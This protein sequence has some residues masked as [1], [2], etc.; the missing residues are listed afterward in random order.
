MYIPIQFFSACKYYKHG[1]LCCTTLVTLINI[2]NDDI[3]SSSSTNYRIQK[4][5]YAI[6]F[7]EEAWLEFSGKQIVLFKRYTN[8]RLSTQ[9]FGWA[10]MRGS[11]CIIGIYRE[12][13]L[14]PEVGNFLPRSEYIHRFAHSSWKKCYVG[15][16]PHPLERDKAE[17]NS[18][19]GCSCST[20]NAHVCLNTRIHTHSSGT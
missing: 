3:S 7:I 12:R 9:L 20:T 1:Y 10:T 4:Y 6:M 18:W 14:K 2:D 15:G 16:Q 8:V 17:V 11:L 19:H 5:V 13:L